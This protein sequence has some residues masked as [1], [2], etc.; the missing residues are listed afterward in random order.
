MKVYVDLIFV[1]NVLYDFLILISVSLLLKKNVSFKRILFGCLIGT[2]TMIT[3]FLSLNKIVLLLLKLITSLSMVIVTFGPKKFYEN[4]FYFYIITIIIGGFQYLVTGDAYRVNIVIMG[5]LSPILI[6]LYIKSQRDYK[7]EITKHYSVVI[8]DGE[9][10]YTCTGYMDTGNTLKD[11]LTGYPVILIKDTYA[12]SSTRTFF[13][14]YRVLGSESILSCVMVDKVLV[15]NREVKVL[16]G[17]ADKG[18]FK[19]GIDCILNEYLR[20]V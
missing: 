19:P 8:V 3:L 1:I 20:S 6:G 15:E 2:S 12:F 5:I 10:A 17:L 11:P 16:L 4:L 9:N 18:L 14:P 13:V 7:L